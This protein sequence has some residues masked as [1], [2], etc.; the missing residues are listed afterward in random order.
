MRYKQLS[1]GY[2]VEISYEAR[3]NRPLFR[4]ATEAIW[5]KTQAAV[6][7]VQDTVS[8]WL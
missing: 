8:L 4:D 3:V 6:L 2:K 7:H 5:D 1:S